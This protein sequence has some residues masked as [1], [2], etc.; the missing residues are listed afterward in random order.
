MRSN[1]SFR[2]FR[3][4][5]R[6]SASLLSFKLDRWRTVHLAQGH[7]LSGSYTIL[8]QPWTRYFDANQSV[9]PHAQPSRSEGITK[10]WGAI[11]NSILRNLLEARVKNK[12]TGR[13]SAVKKRTLSFLFF[14]S[15]S[16]LLL[17]R[18]FI[19]FCNFVFFIGKA[20]N[21]SHGVAKRRIKG[22]ENRVA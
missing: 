9:I 12:I 10:S 16:R 13:S 3:P 1:A 21:D 4:L 15:S 7:V 22:N 19:Y 8:G 2:F 18:S 5:C 14:C 17:F 6:I 11:E 20:E